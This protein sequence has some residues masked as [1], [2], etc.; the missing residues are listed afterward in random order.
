M[1]HI[2]I[3]VNAWKLMMHKRNV[4]KRLLNCFPFPSPAETLHSL[5]IT[6]KIEHDMA[7][8]NQLLP[9][10]NSLYATETESLSAILLTLLLI[11][12]AILISAITPVSKSLHSTK[13]FLQ[14]YKRESTMF[15]DTH[16]FF[17]FNMFRQR[18]TFKDVRANCF[19]ASLLR[20]Q[21]HTPRHA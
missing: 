15:I 1:L 8:Y 21:I 13:H 17:F 19:C 11:S 2:I 14:H 5:G 9:S 20:T 3:R 16:G 18:T 7:Q 12:V 10:K 4:I 6:Y